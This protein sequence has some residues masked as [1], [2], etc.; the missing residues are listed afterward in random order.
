M[1]SGKQG[2]SFQ[3]KPINRRMNNVKSTA[4]GFMTSQDEQYEDFSEQNIPIN[5]KRSRE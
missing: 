5:K 1:S 2:V 4:K 3:Y